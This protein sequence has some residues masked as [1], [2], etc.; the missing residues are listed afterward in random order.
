M[1]KILVLGHHI[2]EVSGLGK[3]VKN[4]W[5][6]IKGYEIHLVVPT[7]RGL[8][9]KL[10]ERIGNMTI[11]YASDPATLEFYYDN[12]G[13]DLVFIEGAYPH[14]K[15][16]DQA[17]NRVRIEVP[18][19]I[20]T[21]TDHPPIPEGLKFI[22]RD[23]DLVITPSKFSKKVLKEAG[24]KKVIVLYH[25]VDST[26]YKPIPV[27]QREDFIW[28]CV[29]QNNIRKQ[30]DRLLRAR[31]LFP[32]GKL[33][34]TCKPTASRDMWS[35]NLIAISRELGLE[36]AVEWN[37]FSSKDVP[38]EEKIMPLIY[39][40]F[41]VHVLPTG[42]ESGG[43]TY[44]EAMACGI[45]NIT[46]DCGV[47]RELIGDAGLYIKVAE[48]FWTKWGIL[49]LASVEDLAEKM[50]LIYENDDM[51]IKLAKKGLK[52]A[53]KFNWNVPAIKLQKILD[54]FLS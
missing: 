8:A 2:N 40:E 45:I 47:A 46:T 28:G 26:V 48:E 19:I 29:A 51:L 4:L 11:Y 15:F 38:M 16:W 25:G 12:I 20:Y 21:V 42:G 1:K 41:D 3:V 54:T 44:L 32:H 30:L 37:K 33:K 39:N 24:V 34:F 9:P 6:R 23:A 43:L 17:M 52:R 13:P 18:I 36:D 35:M 14:M 50:K 5:T 49:Y 31:K 53:W 7:G 22:Y 10:P 27:P